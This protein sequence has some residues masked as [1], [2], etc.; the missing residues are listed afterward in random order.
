VS[1]ISSGNC[2]G[3][4]LDLRDYFGKD[5]SRPRLQRVGWVH[6]SDVALGL[7]HHGTPPR[8]MMLA[9]M[10]PNTM[11]WEREAIEV[12]GKNKNAATYRHWVRECLSQTDFR[13]DFEQAFNETT[14]K[15]RSVHFNLDGMEL[16]RAWR[17]GQHAD[18]YAA[19]VTNWEFVQVLRDAGLRAKTVF[20]QNGK[21]V[22][23]PKVLNRAAAT[24]PP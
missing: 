20:W 1:R 13:F 8:R 16:G 3:S 18:P 9:G 14:T 4:R 2:P 23:L 7:T 24:L 12:F 19:G 11:L 5:D 15:A 6:L 22:P 10:P 21:P 17:M